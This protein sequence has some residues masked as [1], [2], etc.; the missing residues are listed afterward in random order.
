[1]NRHDARRQL[2][3]DLLDCTVSTV[4]SKSLRKRIHDL[5]MRYG[6]N[7]SQFIRAVLE[8]VDEDD[9]WEKLLGPP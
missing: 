7:T 4:I 3:S 8:M 2:R 9:L 1:M 5:R 6:M